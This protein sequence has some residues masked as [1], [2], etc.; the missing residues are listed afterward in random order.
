VF[1]GG[2]DASR[3]TQEATEVEVELLW[4]QLAEV[5]GRVVGKSFNFCL[6]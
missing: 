5:D 6:F 2:Y 3:A 4:V 1:T